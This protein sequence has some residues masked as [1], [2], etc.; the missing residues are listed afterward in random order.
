M[1]II[2]IV[3][4][5]LSLLILGHETGHF[6]VAKAFGLKVDE[7]GFGFPP[8]I[9][10]WKKG[11]TEYSVNWLPFGGFVRIGG[12]NG[13]FAML[14]AD[15]TANATE[16]TNA[17]PQDSS[18]LLYAQPAWKRSLIM[19]AGVFINFIIG[20]LFLSL[21]LM[22]GAP[23][24]LVITSVEP[25]SPAAQ[26]GIMSDDIVK[27]FTTAQSFIDFI[28]AHQGVSTT[29]TVARGDKELTFTVTPRVN[30]GPNEGA[31]GV[32]LEEAGQAREPFFTSLWYGLE[33]A[34]IVLV[35]T[36]QA[37]YQLIEQLFVHASLLPG[38][39]GPVGIFGVAEETGKI[40]LVYLLQLLGIISINLTIVN[41]IPF[42]ALDGGRF[43]M[44]IIEK[45]K[46]KAISARTEAIV[47]GLGFA[48]LITLMILLT[49]RDVSGLI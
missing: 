24:A 2:I 27:N 35:L 48:F 32:E 31:L 20:W 10:A 46:G 22:I 9:K 28:N 16:A 12:E 8:R 47:N 6:F 1:L 23:Q 3:I 39:V 7:F 26:A 40:G 13:E 43:L 49:I 36:A 14:G 41:L 30:P 21:V 42:P 44:V 19:L 18:R 4:V 38:V 5:G 29:V 37:F 45:I 15:G 25:N 17:A 11:E 34:G 33:N